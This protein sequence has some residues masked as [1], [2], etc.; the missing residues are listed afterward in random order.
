[1][2][3]F[4]LFS[5]KKRSFK[6]SERKKAIKHNRETFLS[7]ISFFPKSAQ[8]KRMYAHKIRVRF[9]YASQLSID[10]TKIPTRKKLLYVC[11]H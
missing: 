9:F 11:I 2:I 10:L 6:V 8:R 7:N 3:M 5:G 1:M 4:Q